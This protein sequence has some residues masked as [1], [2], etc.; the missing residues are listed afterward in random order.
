MKKLLSILFLFIAVNSNA[1]FT[2]FYCNSS[3]GS[4][5][6][7]GDNKTL[8]TST[9]GDWGVASANRFTAAA[10]TPFSAVSVGDF[11]SIY[12]D[13]STTTSYISRV[14]AVNAGGASLDVS[15]TVISGSSP[16]ISATGRSCTVGGVWK[17]PNA[18]DSFP[19]TILAGTM[20]NI[21]G[22][23][24]R[25][26]FKNNASYSITAAIQVNF[27][28]A[29]FEGYTT[30]PGDQG[31]ATFDAGSSAIVY[32][33]LGN[34]ADNTSY[35]N[36][37]FTGSGA[38]GANDGVVLGNG[39][40][41]C[42]F[43]RVA[44]NGSKGGG[45]TLNNGTNHTLVETEVSN[46]QSGNAAAKGAY[47]SGGTARFIRAIAHDGTGS[48]AAG[49]RLGGTMFSLEDCIAETVQDGIVLSVPAIIRGF[50]AYNILG[51]GIALTGTS[52]LFVIENSNFVKCSTNGI[53]ATGSVSP[54]G[55]ITNCGFGTGTMANG[56]NTSSLGNIVESGSINY[57]A[58]MNPWA[59]PAN[60]DFRIT[61]T[62]AQGTGRGSFTETSAGY[63]GTI[64]YPD[65]GAAQHLD[66]GPNTFYDST[67]YDSLFQ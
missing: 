4:N 40:L 24:V 51:N 22:D 50:E 52:Q 8:T 13:T 9:N 48:N 28:G 20:T 46:F 29:R 18:A 23:L 63:S 43:Q 42:L 27:A 67:L 26:N 19:F 35:V 39:T 25:A 37:K 10:G 57:S 14:T 49:F 21:A 53:T 16:T 62:E 11:A 56:A 65:I 31:L 3:A 17:G 55:V 7:A 64:G 38:T 2:E 58:D 66:T 61:L 33:N 12:F 45:F 1:A 32:L 60:G 34:N 36:L 41:S 30:T 47:Q 54:Y 15:G 5:I 59:D 6:N 44:V